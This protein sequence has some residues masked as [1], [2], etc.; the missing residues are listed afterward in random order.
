MSFIEVNRARLFYEV[1]GKEHSQDPPVV[2]IHGAPSTGQADWG[3]IAPLLG[4][5]FQV[6]L[7]DCRG[8]G[9]STNPA[10]TYSFREM[11]D[12]IAALVRA[13]GYSRAHIIGHSNG[14]NIALVT[15]LEHPE[16]VQNAVLQA[17]NA[18]VSQDLL[19]RE[20]AV[21]DPQRVEREDPAWIEKMTALHG[22]T[23]GADYW[24]RLLQITLQEI[25]TQPN[26]TPEELS[27]VERPVLVIQGEQDAVNAPAGHA[28]FIAQ[29]IPQAE[30]WTPEMV[31]H[32]VHAERPCE[33][34][35][36][37]SDFLERRGDEPNDALYRLGRQQYKDKRETI[38]NLR[39]ASRKTQAGETKISLTGEVLTQ[40]QLQAAFAS[41]AASRV[42]EI[43][44][45]A[46]VLLSEQTP[47]GL[48]RRGVTDLRREP[49]N[50]S[51]RLSQALLGEALRV[52]EERGEW[53]RVRLEKD[54]Y[55]GW[56][57]SRAISQ[58]DEQ[59]CK[60]YQA[61]GNAVVL[62]GLAQA[63]TSPALAGAERLEAG[64]IPFGVKIIAEEQPDGW[65]A[66]RLPDGRRWWLESPSLM[67]LE[68][69][70][71]PDLPG[72]GFAISL[73][74]RFIGVPYLWGG[75]TPFGYDCS[76]FAQTFLALLGVSA[77]RDADQ[78]HRAATAVQGPPQPG[79]LLFFGSE[80]KESHRPISHVGIALGGDEL[81]HANGTAWGVSI[82]SLDPG[83]PGYSQWLRENLVS[84]GRF[85]SLQSE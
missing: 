11:A 73:L 26:Y 54:G 63:Y 1:Y 78:Q 38:F 80:G 45:E 34:I 49:D 85:W 5:K 48:A 83:R 13:L 33:W 74:R 59:E 22:A 9:H 65:T 55:L 15:L 47:W 46:R 68:K 76:G 39:L 6:I 50:H 44:A 51:E 31:G 64:K 53:V 60:K 35:G 77:P 43:E 81:I 40:D 57:H 82:N 19:E 20:P 37:V 10:G 28:Q 52:L 70:P 71:R 67:P 14:G 8:H 56:L 25:L 23:H 84:Y 16:V 42:G 3:A 61:D 75:R 36:R 30:I 18:Y 21:F 41:L 7:P 58:A 29:H 27:Q 66:V 62:D 12:D 4:Q 17:A 2:L 72:I 79:D 24:R 69:L 32:T